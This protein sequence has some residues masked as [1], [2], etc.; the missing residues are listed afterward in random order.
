MNFAHHTGPPLFVIELLRRIVAVFEQ[1]L[2]RPATEKLV[3]KE[4]VLLYQV[5]HKLGG[6]KGNPE[7]KRSREVER[8]RLRETGERVT[9]RERGRERG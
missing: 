9:E 3:R 7:V 1:Y 4:A 2:T 6:E 5:Q 8:E